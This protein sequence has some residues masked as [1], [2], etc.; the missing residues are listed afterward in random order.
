M[1]ELPIAL[2][3]GELVEVGEQSQVEFFYIVKVVHV[4]AFVG[5]RVLLVL[6]IH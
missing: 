2:G 4:R 1:S 6:N 3:H 5:L